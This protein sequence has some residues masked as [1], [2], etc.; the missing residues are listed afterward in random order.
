L[1]RAK[2]AVPS[3]PSS[4]VDAKSAR[5]QFLRARPR[6]YVAIAIGLVTALL[7]P[8]PAALTRR[9]VIGWDV[10][11]LCFLAM[12]FV[13]AARATPHSM[14]RRAAIE[15]PARWLFLGLMAGAAWFSMFALLGL[16]HDGRDASGHVSLPLAL[17]AGATIFLSWIFAHVTFAVHYVHDYYADL[18]AARPKGLLFPGHP[19]DPDY[20]DFLYFSFVVGMTC[21]V[22]DVQVATRF[23]RR[24]VLAHGIVSFLFNTVVLALCINLL[25]GQL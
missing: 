1:T 11:I 2:E 20:W 8:E 25:A 21:Q 9:A 23:W 22:S 10:G 6:L 12:M 14:H 16:L 13:L 15:D 18:A 24:L 7:L 3:P 4:I 19:S 17:L 5:W